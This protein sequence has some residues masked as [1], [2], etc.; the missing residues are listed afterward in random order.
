[1][2]YSQVAKGKSFSDR[3]WFTAALAFYQTLTILIFS[4]TCSLI[5]TFLLSHYL[6][7]SRLLGHTEKSWLVALK[8]FPSLYF[9]TVLFSH[10]VITHRGL[11]RLLYFFFY[12]LCIQSLHPFRLHS[13]F[14]LV[15]NLSSSASLFSPAAP[16]N[17]NTTCSEGK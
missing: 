9:F 12:F 16:C 5:A 2:R 11:S 7:L 13:S 6:T 4:F 3:C 17:A 10:I 1:M 15:F 8:Q 14:F